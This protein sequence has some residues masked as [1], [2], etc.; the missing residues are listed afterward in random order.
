MRFINVSGKKKFFEHEKAKRESQLR[1][2]V[3]QGKSYSEDVDFA[4]GLVQR[5]QTRLKNSAEVILKTKDLK[6]IKK[7][8][9]KL[10][11][12]SDEFMP[13]ERDYE[14]GREL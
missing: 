6:E 10:A 13:D 1:D 9:E 4:K 12:F 11:E 7:K 2:Q 3:L 14:N 8:V 5:V